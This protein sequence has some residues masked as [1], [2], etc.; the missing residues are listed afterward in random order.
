MLFCRTILGERILLNNNI[1]DSTLGFAHVPFTENYL[2]LRHIPNSLLP[3]NN[4]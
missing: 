3:E 1:K 2:P 4:F